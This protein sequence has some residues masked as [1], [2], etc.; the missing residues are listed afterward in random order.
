MTRSG[1]S[2][3][4]L[5]EAPGP[6]FQHHHLLPLAL[7]RRSQIDIF[8]SELGGTGFS[9]SDRQTNCLWLPAEERLAA[10]VGAAMHRGP[11]PH[12]SEV[13]AARVD[14][15]RQTSRRLPPGQRASASLRRLRRLQRALTHILAGQGPRLVRLN[16]RDPLR[17]FVDYSQLDAAIDDL[18]NLDALSLNGDG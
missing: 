14:R 8:L 10:R 11:H 3:G 18:I 9:L 17:L 6:G 2:I 16:R 12:Y 1:L 15:I 13:V 5:G 4:R 7:R